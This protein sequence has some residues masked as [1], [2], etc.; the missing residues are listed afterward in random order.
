MELNLNHLKNKLQHELPGPKAQMKLAPSSRN[1]FSEEGE[2]IEAAVLILL[3]PDTNGEWST[4]F[5][6]RQSYDGHHS[7][8]VSF[9]GGKVEKEDDSLAYTAKRE[10]QEEIGIRGKEVEIL[11]KITELF[12][13]VSNFQVHPFIGITYKTPDFNIDPSEV[14]YLI[15]SS[16]KQLLRQPVLFTQRE[17]NNI[18]IDIPYFNIKDE[19]IWGATAMILSEFIELLQ[20]TIDE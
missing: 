17:Y 1:L 8:Q 7:G 15:T 5:M 10:S 16:L 20:S 2:I 14:D 9:P 4:V 13:P 11:G 18:T 12:I 3:F 19:M 6:K